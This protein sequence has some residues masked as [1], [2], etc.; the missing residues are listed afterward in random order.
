[1]CATIDENAYGPDASG[2]KVIKQIRATQFVLGLGKRCNLAAVLDYRHRASRRRRQLDDEGQRPLPEVIEQ[3][4]PR[5][6][7]EAEVGIAGLTPDQWSNET[8]RLAGQLACRDR[9]C[10]SE[11]NLRERDVTGTSNAVRDP[12]ALGHD[13]VADDDDALLAA[14]SQSDQAVP[15]CG[16]ECI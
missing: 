3:L 1:A 7:L 15:N 12:N 11:P 14:I 16:R 13:I 8:H 9:G 6:P 4:R 5:H 10:C 2:S